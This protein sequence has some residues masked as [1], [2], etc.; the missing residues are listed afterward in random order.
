MNND[1]NNINNKNN[2]MG[3]IMFRFSEYLF[4]GL[5]RPIFST[6]MSDEIMFPL[7][8]CHVAQSFVTGEIMILFFLR[9]KQSFWR[10]NKVN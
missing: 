8:K 5:D 9:T 6:K 2:Q 10:E 7:V 3:Q 4:G 1:N